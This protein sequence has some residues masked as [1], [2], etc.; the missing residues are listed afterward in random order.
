MVATSNAYNF[1]N[2]NTGDLILAAY[3]RLGIRNSTVTSEDFANARTELN[4][5]L[6]HW[7]NKNTNLF[8][9]EQN[10]LPLYPGQSSYLLPTATV[11]VRECAL[12]NAQRQIGGTPSASSG[13]AANAFDGDPLTACT[14]TAPNGFIEYDFG[15]SIN[16]P[17][18]LGPQVIQYVGITTPENIYLSLEVQYAI[19]PGVWQT[20]YTIPPQTFLALQP[21]WFVLPYQRYAEYWRIVE[22][23]GATINISELYFNI[24]VNSKIMQPTPREVY[25]T[26]PVQQASFTGGGNVTGVT[27]GGA[28]TYWVNRV[29]A[30]VINLYST[31]DDAYNF[32]L[33]NRVRQ[34]QDVGTMV[35]GQDAPQR[36]FQAMVYELANVLAYQKSVQPQALV[37]NLNG[38]AAETY[39]Q[40][41]KEDKDSLKQNV[42]PY[43]MGR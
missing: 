25:F 27:G 4:L 30:A 37:N 35:E 42:M 21:T 29:G 40:A 7:V 23:G 33:F 8:T 19:A 41:A 18:T 5:I 12:L 10:L 39:I 38:V 2:F 34:I 9:I 26:Y 14:Q 6:S 28:S 15:V 43:S 11:D 17:T 3:R 16:P 13:N 32:L 20:I 31:A 1:Q 36:F 22:T 24:G